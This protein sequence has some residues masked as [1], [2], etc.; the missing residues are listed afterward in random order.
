MKSIKSEIKNDT[1]SNTP[2]DLTLEPEFMRRIC[3][4]QQN[5]EDGM[6]SLQKTAGGEYD[7]DAS[8]CPIAQA[9]SEQVGG[10]WV[11]SPEGRARFFATGEEIDLPGNAKAFI[12]NFDMNASTLPDSVS[13]FEFEIPHR[14][15]RMVMGN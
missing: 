10:L 5:I 13:T 9:L 12:A 4:N 7:V 6:F 8:S 3:V 15:F 2:E 1:T 11:I 14:V